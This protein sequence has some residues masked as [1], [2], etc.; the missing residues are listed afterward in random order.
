MNRILYEIVYTKPRL[1]DI[2][3]PNIDRLAQ[4]GIRFTDHYTPANTCSPTRAALMTGRY[5]ARTGVNAVIFYDS[6]EGMPQ[7][8]ILPNCQETVFLIDSGAVLTMIIKHV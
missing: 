5:Q 7:K 2:D 4:E 3:T 1:F 8:E 6:V